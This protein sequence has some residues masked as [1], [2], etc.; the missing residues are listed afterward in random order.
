MKR[1][2][3]YNITAII[4]L[5][6]LIPILIM[7]TLW[8]ISPSMQPTWLIRQNMLNVTPKGTGIE[9]VIKVVESN[10][11]WRWNGYISNGGLAIIGGRPNVRDSS[12]STTHKVIGE[13]TI[14]VSQTRNMSLVPYVDI[15]YAFDENDK[16][17]EIMVDKE[18]PF[19]F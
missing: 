3:K 13:K 4:A 16:L 15:Y 11:K 18:Y 9:E 8:L 6:I 5:G 14:M 2:K 17:I 19:M 1:A 12:A 7:I 10:E